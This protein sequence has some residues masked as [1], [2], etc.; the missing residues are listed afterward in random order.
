[1][2]LIFHVPMVAGAYFLLAAIYAGI[3]L[4]VQRLWSRR[5]LEPR[6]V[7]RALWMGWGLGLAVL[8]AWNLWLPVDARVYAVLAPLALCGL[9]WTR[10]DL[11]K[12]L[13]ADRRR[14]AGGCLAAAAAAVALAN[15][16]AAQP[17]HYDS[18][19]YHVMAVRWAGRYPAVPGLGNLFGNLAFNNAFFLY[20]AS[21]DVGPF[22]GRFHHLA[23]GALIGFFLLQGG[24]AMHRCFRHGARPEARDF[25]DALM[26][27]P[28]LVWMRHNAAFSSPSPDVPVFLLGAVLGSEVLGLLASRGT[29]GESS[30]AAFATVAV[31]F[32]AAVGLVN[33]LSM[34]GLAGAAVLVTACAAWNGSGGSANRGRRLR[35][36][37]VLVLAVVAPWLARG[38]LLSGYPAYP[39]TLGGIDVDWR[40][41]AAAAQRN[42]DVIRAWARQ[43]GVPPEEALGTWRWIWP[44]LNRILRVHAADVTVPL[45]LGVLGL[46]LSLKAAKASRCTS[47]GTLLAFAAVPAAGILYCLLSA[48]SP[49]FAGAAFWVFGMG[50]LSL[51]LA[52]DGR[53]QAKTVLPVLIAVL[54]LRDLHPLEPVVPWQRDAGPVRRGLTTQRTT[55]S[56]LTVHVPRSGDQC[57]DAPLPCTP[58]FH[59]NLE[60]RAENDLS[61][62][63]R[64]GRQE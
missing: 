15:L 16:C 54:A 46:L 61:R 25:F 64:L 55:D 48:P 33:K 12:L 24:Y 13:A 11:W 26:L 53:P 43:P 9:G 22:A 59:P 7:L 8:Q 23:S 6:D 27:V 45:G 28:M 60:L 37:A 21:L 50:L 17:G 2:Q 39:S 49:R 47:L 19:F 20:A 62:G 56:G 42:V 14:A 1:M 58:F 40:I 18:G 10:R 51:Y 44:W 52:G 35:W 38:L 30:R 29:D 57:W 32:L 63:F 34:A 3:G 5:G 31:A 41:P 36:S 4:L